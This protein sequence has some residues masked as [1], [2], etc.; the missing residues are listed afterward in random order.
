MHIFAHFSR[1]CA[2]I[3]GFMS[4]NIAILASG[5]GTNAENIIRYFRN[6]GTV[7]VGL[8]LSNRKAAF[9]LERARSLNVPFAYMEK[10][11]WTDGEAVLSLLKD[12]HIDFVVLA[13]FLARV[14]DCILH[15]YPN[16]IINIHP[17][18]LPKFG[19]K[20]MYGDRVHQAVVAAG[21]TETGITIHYL[22]EHFDEGETIVQYKCPVLP[23]D[24]A[25]DVAKKVHALEYEYYP[26]VIARLL[27]EI[28]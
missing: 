23:Q 7:N 21:E 25:E 20:G 16:K 19:G 18:L 4:K 11:E 10:A 15:A 1:F 2:G 14:P 12:K 24:T 3:G 6:S 8:V 5:N 22:N 9:V 27:S 28:R 17:S 26:Q 13:G